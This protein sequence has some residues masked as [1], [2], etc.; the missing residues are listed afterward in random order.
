[1]VIVLIRR[2]RYLKLDCHVMST[3]ASSL[4][5]KKFQVLSECVPDMLLAWKK[6]KTNLEFVVIL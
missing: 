6:S 2:I 4:F 3:H 1:M 5:R